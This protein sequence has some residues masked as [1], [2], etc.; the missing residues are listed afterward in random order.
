MK[1]ILQ[2]MLLSLLA[3]QITAQTVTTFSGTRG[4]AG[5]SNNVSLSAALWSQPNS[6]CADGNGNLWVTD[7]GNHCVKMIQGTTVYNRAGSQF[8]P[9]TPGA[10][11]YANAYSSSAKFNAPK[12]IVCDA[13]NVI[14]VCD[15]NNNAIRRIDAFT[16]I[17]NSQGVTTLCGAPETTGIAVKGTTDGVGTAARFDGPNGICKDNSGNLYVTDENNSSIRK[18]VISTGA[19][20][21]LC[22]SASGTVGGLVDGSFATA[23]FKWPRGIAFSASENALYV[24]D[25]GNGRIRKIDLTAQTVSVY[26]GSTTGSRN[27]FMGNDGNRLTTANSRSTEGI[28]IDYQGNIFFSSSNNANTIRRIEKTTG[29]VLTLA[30]SHQVAADN[31]GFYT[32]SRFNLPMGIYLTPDKTTMILCDN[33]NGLIRSIDL[34]PVADFRS[35]YTSLSTG[36]IATIT[37]TSLSMVNS[38]KWTITP[39]TLNT[40]YQFANSTS[41]T[42]QNPQIKFLTAGTYTI[43][44]SVNNPYGAAVKIKPAYIVV[45]NG[46]GQPTADFIADKL[47][48]PAST[49][50]TFTNQTTNTAS[51]TYSWAF[52]PATIAYINSTTQNSANPQVR[53][54]TGGYYSVTLNVSHPTFT[55]APKVK[56]NYIYITGVGINNSGNSFSFEVFP[57]P[58]SGNFTIRTNESLK[59]ATAEVIDLQGRSLATMNLENTM[60]Q[61][62]NC[63]GLTSGIYILKVKADDKISTQRIVIE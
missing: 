36:A 21:T 52:N 48:G 39:G 34:R 13:N 54:T 9:G 7:D 20:T 63:K 51:C 38:W 15:Y 2:L 14:Y 16:T 47:W 50:F 41:A 60:E 28:A 46:T 19:V 29:N 22:G 17:G 49:I 53:F 59:G 62:I 58:N 31:D 37:D 32:N 12:G 43:K 33:T 1:R 3:L 61:Q 57:N 8:I 30:G 6:I 42:S 25:Y 27:G 56:T 10:Y 18:I 35:N 4:S 26:L 11:G 40:D 5:N 45:S 24:C 55:V 44:D 23:K